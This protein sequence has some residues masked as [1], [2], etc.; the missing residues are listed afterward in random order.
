MKAKR[1]ILIAAAVLLP[2]ADLYS[3][4]STIGQM[5]KE[6]FE[7]IATKGGKH[8]AKELAE[9]GGEK[10]VQETLEKAYR[11][12]GDTLVQQVVKQANA[13]GP[14]FLEG[15]KISPAR[16]AQ[17]FD[18]L[19]ESLRAGALQ[20]IRREPDTMAALVARHGEPALSM[21]AKHPGIAVDII[22]TLGDDGIRTLAKL[23]T[24]QAIRL[25]RLTPDI[26]KLPAPQRNQWLELV[27]AA[28]EK[29]LDLLEQH[30][31]VL[32]SVTAVS[33]IYLLK[34]QLLGGSEIVVGPDGQSV[35]VERPGLI[36][37]SFRQFKPQIAII[38]LAAGACLVV[39]AGV[40][41]WRTYA[42]S[43]IKIRHAGKSGK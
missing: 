14:A 19:P 16:F 23:D 36:D 28:P 29:I 12:G 26:G 30:P 8:A 13:Y 7:Q 4:A 27:S 38:L 17:A 10:A 39:W 42:L 2:A 35:V 32:N 21:A 25:A 24:D 33:V 31:R 11:E 18:A 34:D 22:S 20:T 1:L 3:Q 37:R 40:H 15:A 6:V 43:K 5:A 41:I 9:L